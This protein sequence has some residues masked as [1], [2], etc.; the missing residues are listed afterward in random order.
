M[1]SPYEILGLSVYD[2]EEVAKEKYRVLCKKYHPDNSVTGDIEKFRKVNEAW[3][4]LKELGFSTEKGIWCRKTLFT[5]E[6]KI[7]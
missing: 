5:M 3:K 1:I 6:R 4:K 2:G 7:I